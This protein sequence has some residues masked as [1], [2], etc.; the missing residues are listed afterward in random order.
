VS[1]PSILLASPSLSFAEYVAPGAGAVARS[2]I[3]SI[4]VGDLQ[5]IQV[6]ATPPNDYQIPQ[7]IPEEVWAA[8]GRL[9][10][11]GFIANLVGGAWD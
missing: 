2:D 5:R 9:A 7:H 6:Y 10:R 11:A 8:G 4:M 3:I 1:A